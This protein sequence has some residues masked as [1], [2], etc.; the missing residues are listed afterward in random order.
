[1]TLLT[2]CFAAGTGAFPPALAQALAEQAMPQALTALRAH[3]HLG[4]HRSP[5]C[6]PPPTAG[7][8]PAQT[9]E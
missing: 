5:T 4:T 9:S 3:P 6:A 7:P 1:M 2:P 8:S